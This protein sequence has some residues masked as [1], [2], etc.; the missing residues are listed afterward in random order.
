MQKVVLV[1]GGGRGIGAGIVEKL[2][3]ENW[4]V[5]FCGRREPAALAER[6]QELTDRYPGDRVAYWQCDVSREE[7]RA[8]LL[9]AILAR[10]GRLDAL[11]NN[12]GVA[13]EV[14]RDLLEMTEESF[15]R[16][17]GINV[18]G[19]LFLTQRIARYFAES[20]TKG[21]IV[22]IGSI[23]ATVASVS[24]G[25]YCISKAAVAMLTRL[26]AVRMA[27]FGVPVYEIR[28][29]VIHSDM[30]GVVREKYDRLIAEGLTLQP[31]WGEPEDIGRAVAMLLRGD[32]AYSTGQ[33]INV[34]GGMEVQRL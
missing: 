12:A 19:P 9:E 4:Q 24:R 27:E 26:F 21:T 32:L 11:V 25:E 14:R 10:F 13:P 16:V 18:R 22:N 15:D 17:M 33:V 1:T 8:G 30:T 23:S 3:Q 7:E 2:L 34:D 29:G 31:R 28:P 5:A 20:G 6:L